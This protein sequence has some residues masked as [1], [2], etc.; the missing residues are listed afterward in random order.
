M[1]QPK[2]PEVAR[3]EVKVNDREWINKKVSA[4]QRSLKEAELVKRRARRNDREWRKE[5]KQREFEK[6]DADY[7][8]ENQ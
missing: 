7:D 1:E 4:R 6:A 2:K 8:E 3:R 5:M